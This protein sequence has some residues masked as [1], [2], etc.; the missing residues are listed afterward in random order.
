M[1]D[2]PGMATD[3]LSFWERAKRDPERT[4]IVPYGD[5]PVSGQT[6]LH[7]T[8][9][10]AHLLATSG[11]ASGEVLAVMLPNGVEFVAWVLAGLQ[12]GLYVTPINTRSTTRELGYIIEDSD[13]G[14]LV[15]HADRRDIVAAAVV[16]AGS[17]MPS[18]SLPATKNVQLHL[19][20]RFRGGVG[21]AL[22]ERRPGRLLLYTSG[23]TGRPKGVWRPL[24]EGDPDRAAVME[25]ERLLSVF[26]NGND[27]LEGPHLVVSPL[28]FGAP[29]M[30]ALA[31]I[32]L[33]QALVLGPQSWD[34]EM[35]L[36]LIDQHRVSSTQMVPT[37]FQR[38]LRLS[39]ETRS[40]YDLRSLRRVSHGGAPCD[41]A[42]KRAMIDWVGPVVEEIYGSTE[43]G[44]TSISATEWLERPGS[45]GRPYGSAV[46]KILDD[47]GEELPTGVVG[48]VFLRTTPF[49]YLNDP[50]K[51]ASRHVGDFYT[52][53]DIG[54]LDEDGYLYLCDRESDVIISGGANVYPAEIESVLVS[55]PLVADAAVIGVPDME[56]GER[57]H[58]LVELL[59]PGNPELDSNLAN[60]LIAYCRE[61]VTPA[62]CPKTLEFVQRGMLRFETGKLRR[63][64]LR[65]SAR[66]AVD[67]TRQ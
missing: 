36:R 15:S 60:E 57:V 34:T 35:V 66:A 3:G 24:S 25:S 58:A 44:G 31:A 67:S 42:T 7:R 27:V 4:A 41:P 55:H 43:G 23:T 45:V 16:R 6:L 61:R 37:M 2:T 62:K 63:H 28:S 9:Q 33:G 38:L 48:R 22:L 54:Y 10:I 39:P 29:L 52:V 46:I 49:Q 20:K 21:P 47:D 1:A 18:P 17:L 12:M 40:K 32:H 13:A 26:S 14:A 5:E 56:W 53:G 50:D 64:E 30:L 51:T 8:N 11:L 59:D 19:A 65:Q